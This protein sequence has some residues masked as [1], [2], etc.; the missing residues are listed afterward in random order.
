MLRS[1]IDAAIER[2][3]SVLRENGFHLPPFAF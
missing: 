2:A 3:K 1:Q